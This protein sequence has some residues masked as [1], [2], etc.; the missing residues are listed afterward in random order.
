[1][2]FNLNE[3]AV[4]GAKGHHIFV[5]WRSGLDRQ[6]KNDSRRQIVIAG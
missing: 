3:Y 1:V 4:K 6:K 5:F 2:D